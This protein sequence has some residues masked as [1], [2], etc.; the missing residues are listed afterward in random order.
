MS[1]TLDGV[2]TLGARPVTPRPRVASSSRAWNDVM[3]CSLLL[4]TTCLVAPPHGGQ[5]QVPVLPETDGEVETPDTLP[6]AT[7]TLPGYGPPLTV[8]TGRWEWWFEYHHEELLDLKRRLPLRADDR[9]FASLSDR[10]RQKTLLPL[11]VDG[12]RRDAVGTRGVSQESN[13]RDVRAAAAMAL[14]RLALPDAIPYIELIIDQDPDLFVRT[15]AILALGVSGQPAAVETLARIFRDRSQPAELRCYAAAGLALID[16][17]YA[18]EII[19]QAL[20]PDGLEALSQNQVQAAV[21]HAAAVSGAPR[22]GD[23]VREVLDAPIAQS[24]F[25]VRALAATALGSIDDVANVTPLLALLDDGDTLVRRAAS[26][27]IEGLTARMNDDDVARLVRR[28]R[29]L[30]DLPTRL[31]LVRALGTVKRDGAREE[32]VRAL[33]DTNTVVRSHA[34]FGLARDVDGGHTD[35]LLAAL[36][37]AS[38]PT[39]RGSYAMA[40]GLLEAQE[41]ADDLAE[42]IDAEGDP[43]VLPYQML[44]LGLIAPDGIDDLPARIAAIVRESHDVEVQR[45]GI[46]SLGLLGARGALDELS[47]EVAAVPGLVDRVT[48][49]YALGVVG[50]RRQLADLV[51]IVEDD[52]QPAFVRAYAI[53]ALGELADPRPLPPSARL[54]RHVELSLD[55]GFLLELYRT[56]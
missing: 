43:Q 8:E 23:V 6:E 38:E 32:L 11:F 13:P 39:L 9:P 36:R 1:E 46:V 33:S 24:E 16:D 53:V 56:L 18:I 14:G 27:S 25:Y 21:V 15:E 28:Y 4:F 29:D 48:Q 22:L 3:W 42:A 55:V 26:A 37:E 30:A 47:S 12:L 7:T 41:A 35:R 49:V 34:A 44:A 52:T 17:A 20:S 45:W 50:D 5:F 51:A 10:D 40:L 54:T 19:G 2:G 31:N